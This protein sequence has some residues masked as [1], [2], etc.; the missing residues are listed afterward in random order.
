MSMKPK[1]K[2]L[3]A[4]QYEN[5]ISSQG[6]EEFEIPKEK[7]DTI[8]NL[9]RKEDTIAMMGSADINN[10]KLL[11]RIYAIAGIDQ[12]VHEIHPKVGEPE[13]NAYHF[14]IQ[15]TSHSN[16]PY[17]LHGPFRSE[18]KIGHHFDISDLDKYSK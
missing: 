11:N 17:I 15:L 16:F 2:H 14:V 4:E 7:W 12:L 13:G 3:T 5:L 10:P 6:W 1:R 9:T 8:S 18:T